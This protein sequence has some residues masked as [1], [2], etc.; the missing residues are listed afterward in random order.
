MPFA[1]YVVNCKPIPDSCVHIYTY[2]LSVA[3]FNVFF[4][5]SLLKKKNVI[6][7]V[8]LVWRGPNVINT[9]K[10]LFSKFE[11]IKKKKKKQSV[12]NLE[13]EVILLF[14][15]FII[16]REKKYFLSKARTIKC[17]Q[18]SSL[19]IKLEFQMQKHKKL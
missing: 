3:L 13:Y 15:I 5:T 7:H 9:K 1:R 11:Y 8:R 18:L 14:E 6:A 10:M 12:N 17:R 19:T 2:R 16:H 4:Q